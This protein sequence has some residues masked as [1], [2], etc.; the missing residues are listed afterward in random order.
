ML[1]NIE[2]IRICHVT[3][4]PFQDSCCCQSVAI[5]LETMEGVDEMDSFWAS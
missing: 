2:E 3:E 4:S 5:S 1:T